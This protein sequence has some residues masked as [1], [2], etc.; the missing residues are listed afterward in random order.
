[1]SVLL[2]RQEKVK[3]PFYVEELGLNLYSSQELSYVIYNHPL[4]V[5]DGFFDERL[6]E[7]LRDQLDLS[8]L[9]A[10]L[11]KWMKSGEHTDDLL[12]M[13]LQECYYYR[14]TEIAKFKQQL[15]GLRKK[16]KADFA[17]AK[18]DYLFQLKQYGKAI[19]QYEALTEFPR[20]AFVD[21][22]FVGRIWNNLGSCYARMFRFSQ[23]YEC[24]KMA[25]ELTKEYSIIRNMYTLTLMDPKTVAEPRYLSMIDEE[26]KVQWGKLYEDARN[27][28]GE[29]EAVKDLEHLF[30]RDPIKRLLGAG[31][32]VQR[33]KQEYRNMI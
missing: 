32:L 6:L 10:K 19:H 12:V 29:S 14:S 23:A 7:F 26:M 24:Y 1:M 9:A 33:W 8:F 3:H 27:Q 5:M 28:A 25:Y 16:H 30:T 13:L 20:D 31:E 11:E 15:A 18:A 17:K 22:F 21:D 4:L 2:C